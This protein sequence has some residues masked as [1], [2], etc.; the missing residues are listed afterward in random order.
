LL[1][2]NSHKIPTLLNGVIGS[3]ILNVSG[4]PFGNVIDEPNAY[5]EIN[6]SKLQQ[7]LYRYKIMDCKSSVSKLINWM[8]GT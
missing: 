6:E 3:I 2:Y 1:L 8:L 4:V 7:L 5:V